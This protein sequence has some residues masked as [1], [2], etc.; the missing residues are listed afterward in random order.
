MNRRTFATLALAGVVQAASPQ[1]A[2]AQKKTMNEAATSPSDLTL[3]YDKPA[4]QWV[5]ALPLG[6]GRLGA[7]V[8]G[9]VADERLQ[10]NEDTLWAG[11]PYDPTNPDALAALPRVRELVFAGRHKEAQDLAGEKMMARPL[12][13]M[14]YQPVGDLHLR[15]DGQDDFSDYRREL[16]LDS[17]VARVTYTA[18]GVRFEREAFA[19]APDQAIVVRLTADTP[20]RIAFSATM[21]SPHSSATTT[22]AAPPG[23]LVLRGTSGNAQGI[24]GAVRWEARVEIQTDGGTVEAGTDRITVRGAGAA[25]LRIVA[26]TSYVNYKD[27]SGDPRARATQC[28]AAGA[29][30]PFER[31]RADHVADHERLFRRVTLDLGA[32]TEAAKLPTDQRVARYGNG[33]NDPH[34]AALYFQFGRYL[35]IASSR[36]GTQPANL[37]GVWNE[38]LA[39][40]WDSKYTV[41]IN[42]E[43]NYWPAEQTNLAECHEPLVRLVEEIA[44]TG[45]HTARVHYN[46][47]GWVCHHNTDGWRATAPVDGPL[48]GLWP[49]GGAWLCTH[50]WQHYAFGGDRAF[51]RRI[52][53]VLKGAAEF[54]LDTL[55]VHPEHRWL[56]TCPSISPENAHHPGVSLCAGPTMD[57]QIVRDLWSACVQAS[58][59]LTT[60]ADFRAGL[61]QKIEQLPPLRIGR[62]GQ[63]QEW[64]D[65]WDAD[66]PEPHHRHVSHLYGLYPSDQI[67]RRGTPELFR[68][69]RK[70]LELRGDAGTG[71]SLGWKINLWARLED[72]ARACKLL[73]DQLTPARTYPNLFDAH[74]PFQIDGNFGATSGIAQMLLQSH[75]ANEIHLLPALPPAWPNGRVTGLRAR[76]GFDVDIVWQNGKLAEA[77]LHSRL[78]RPCT[79]RLGETTVALRTEAGASYRFRGALLE[80]A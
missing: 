50:L 23:T 17:A 29:Q 38:S 1:R 42:T 21:T 16:D 57:T 69:A 13:Q 66:A 35:L 7:M 56:V 6:N 2:R 37:Q 78:G 28:L 64:L 34:L 4:N 25:T 9:G 71:W 77:T 72:G 47:R 20:G 76:G 39:P 53:P 63:L 12:R 19:S 48:W 74:P 67:T 40:P 10:L 60:D 43:M 32:G 62:A 11:Q 70:S 41:N 54:F 5:E 26:A 55:V 24:K 61:G 31:L 44:E 68:A 58:E 49:T 45:R 8:F 65:D 27:V 30:K 46:A 59:I 75:V 73:S 15:F 33:K 52:Y 14:P 51:L 80:R 79:V 18:N 3:W 36:P 22:Q